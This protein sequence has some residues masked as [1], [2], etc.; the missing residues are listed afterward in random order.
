MPGYGPYP[1]L[2]GYLE[3]LGHAWIRAVSA[4]VDT[5]RCWAMP[6]YGQCSSL[7]GYLEVL[8]H[9]WILALPRGG[10]QQIAGMPII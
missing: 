2:C 5:W 4:C 7:C 8:S 6:G 9:A 1:S 3:V 10:G